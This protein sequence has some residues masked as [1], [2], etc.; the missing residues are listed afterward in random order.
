MV[1][2][3]VPD[4]I[5][6]PLWAGF[7]AHY[8]WDVGANCG[9][10]ITNMEQV[11]TAFTCFEP[12][13]DSFD[14]ARAAYPAA[15]ILQLAVSDENG[16]IELAVPGDEQRETGQLVTPG[17]QGMEWE[18]E[19]WGDV[20][21]VTVAARTGDSLA[22]EFRV[23][24][25]IKVDTEGH[26]TRVMEGAYGILR[27]RRTSWLIEFHSPENAEACLGYLKSN[28]YEPHIVRHPNYPEG[29]DMWHQHGWIR[30]F[31]RAVR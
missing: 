22:V 11:C 14:Y 4:P 3:A 19:S 1:R 16:W 25:F 27:R 26:E 23:P 13:K 30:A 20:E 9:Q 7:H 29:S 8:G 15:H 17:V 5:D 21:K 12:C 24:D 28:E 31:A 2:P 18:P 10:S 6:G